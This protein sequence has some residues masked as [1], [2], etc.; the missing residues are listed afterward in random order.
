VSLWIRLEGIAPHRP[1]ESSVLGS[2]AL[3]QWL[4][5]LGALA[6]HHLQVLLRLAGQLCELDAHAVA[7]TVTDHADGADLGA[8]DIDGQ[9]EPRAHVQC[10][11]RLDE[12]AAQ[13][14]VGT[15]APPS[16]AAE[17]RLQACPCPYRLPLRI[18]SLRAILEVAD[19]VGI[20]L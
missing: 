10:S 6:G 20:L 5:E 4:H 8:L 17:R 3:L 11:R 19:A 18:A 12:T 2:C 13:A 1:Q 15:H 16:L 14:D 9:L 7:L